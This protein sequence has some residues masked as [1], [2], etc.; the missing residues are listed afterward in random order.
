[1]FDLFE[2]FVAVHSKYNSPLSKIRGYSDGHYNRL[3]FKG[4]RS[5]IHI[6]TF[7]I[8]LPLFNLFNIK[9]ITV[10]VFL[11]ADKFLT[12]SLAPRRYILQCSVI[13]C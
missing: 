12:I 13:V 1:M 8:K 7:H 3:G 9:F 11:Y 4:C 6:G 5:M 10:F 2:P